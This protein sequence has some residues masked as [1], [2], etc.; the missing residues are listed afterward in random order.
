MGK[1]MK[2]KIK[3]TNEPMGNLRIIKDF[4]P[5]PSDL[6]LKDRTVKVTIALSQSSLKFF[7]NKAKQVRAPY[8][9]MIRNLLD[10]YVG[11]FH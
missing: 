4:L 3:Y 1:S 11:Q 8:Q 5:K 10:F 7:K 6:V 9:R 2:G